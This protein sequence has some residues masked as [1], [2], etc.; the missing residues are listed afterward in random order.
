MAKTGV[1]R[2]ALTRNSRH[3][4][5][6]PYCIN[7]TTLQWTIENPNSFPVP[8]VHA[9]LDGIPSIDGIV[10]PRNNDRREYR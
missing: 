6:D 8:D 3:L 2:N 1:L 10:M 5:L 4:L 7:T 9:V